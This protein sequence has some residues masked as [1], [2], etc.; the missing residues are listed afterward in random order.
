M[1]PYEDSSKTDAVIAEAA[2]LDAILAQIDQ[3]RQDSSQSPTYG[4]D[5][6]WHLFARKMR[7]LN[8]Q[9]YGTRIQNWL[10]AHYQWVKVPASL[11]RGDVRDSKGQYREV[12]VTFITPSNPGANFVQIRPYQN[13]A[14]YDL[15]VID[16]QYHVTRLRLTKK[17]MAK[18]LELM[19]VL[20]HGTRTS[21]ADNP[22]QE[23]AIRLPWTPEEDGVAARWCRSYQVESGVQAHTTLTAAA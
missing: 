9:S 12:K 6:P 11:N 23:F 10:I 19:G 13:I 20:T 14:G 8:P 18:E 5:L 21:A 2:R 17:Q 16:D 7:L 4:F 22:N 1:L 3:V 15:F